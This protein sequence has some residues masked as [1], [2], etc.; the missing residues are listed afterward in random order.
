MPGFN[1]ALK[2]DQI[3]HIVNY[4]LSIPFEPMP[5]HASGVAAPAEATPAA[6][7]AAAAASV[8]E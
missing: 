6:T 8:V 7:D 5:G 1:K 3:W 2:H 4:V